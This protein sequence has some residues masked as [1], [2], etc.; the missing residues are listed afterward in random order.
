MKYDINFNVD[1]KYT[2]KLPQLEIDEFE[3]VVE[4]YISQYNMLDLNIGKT[5][6][7]DILVI[8]AGV[9]NLLD[10]TTIPAT[11]GTSGTAHSGG[12]VSVPIGWGRTFF[13]KAIINFRKV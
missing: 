1:Y 10:V 6:F 8:S 4:G 12:T 3:Q 2:G 11:G 7:K 13:I 5:F 9:K